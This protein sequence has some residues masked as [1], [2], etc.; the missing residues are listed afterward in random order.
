MNHDY[1]HCLDYD[2]ETCPESCFRARLTRDYK[3]RLLEFADITVS[4]AHLKN[5]AECE[6]TGKNPCASCIRRDWCKMDSKEVISC[7]QYEP[8][9][10]THTQHKPKHTR[11]DIFRTM[12]VEDLAEF[13]CESRFT[14]GSCP[15]AEFCKDG[16]IGFIDWLQQEA[17]A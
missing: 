4:W 13:L 2:I 14:C 7:A 5:T 15:A 8:T 17:E 6:I 16:H 9:S 1:H 3:E 11:F 12:S 10:E